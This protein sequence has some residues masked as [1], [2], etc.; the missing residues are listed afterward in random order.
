MITASDK[1]YLN[2]HEIM[3]MIRKGQ[4]FRMAI[5]LFSDGYFITLLKQQF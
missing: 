1:S 2:L 5:L 3:T 4:N